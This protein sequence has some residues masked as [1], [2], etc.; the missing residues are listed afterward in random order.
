MIKFSKLYNFV[1]ILYC[2]TSKEHLQLLAKENEI[3]YLKEVIRTM[4]VKLQDAE[5]KVNKMNEMHVTNSLLNDQNIQ[6]NEQNKLLTK[7]LYKC[8][9]QYQETY[10][11][12]NAQL[13]KIQSEAINPI[14]FGKHLH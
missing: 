11:K 7:E 3:T 14:A 12:Y 9:Q 5:T 6:F 10:Q 2:S 13:Q 4:E 8:Q 1:F